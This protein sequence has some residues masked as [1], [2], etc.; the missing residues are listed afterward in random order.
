MNVMKII[1][2]GGKISAW[3]IGQYPAVKPTPGG[4]SVSD[5]TG[6]VAQSSGVLLS[7][8]DIDYV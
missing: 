5:K 8:I 4:I 3:D 6:H 7:A 2:R 1:Y